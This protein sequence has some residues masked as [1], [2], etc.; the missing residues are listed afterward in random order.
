VLESVGS[1]S[2][3]AIRLSRDASL[4]TPA[5]V[6]ARQQTA[7]R[8]RGEHTWW[9]ADGALTLSLVLGPD[10]HHLA[11]RDWPKISLA[12]AVAVRDALAEVLPEA[13]VTTKWPN[14]VLIGEK[15]VAGILI[16]SPGGGP[17]ASTRLVIGIGVNV[18][19]SFQNAPPELQETGT[20]LC[21]IDGRKHDLETL[22]VGL[23]QSIERCL[24]NIH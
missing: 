19:N 3:H 14:D 4:P 11:E 24:T 20:A 1:T 21:D 15:K 12:M 2:D 8:G 9:S 23:I 22:L 17:P 6:V 5:L 18:N 13:A 7:G 16:E 10:D